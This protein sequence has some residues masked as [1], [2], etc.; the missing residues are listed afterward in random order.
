MPVKKTKKPRTRKA[1]A[2]K[3]GLKQ[4]Q[5]QKQEQKVNVSV[6]AGGSGGGTQFIPMPS[7]PAFDYAQLASLIRPANTVDVPIR[8]QVNPEPLPAR[9]AEAPSLAEEMPSA[10]ARRG[11]PV[12]SKN[13]PKPVAYP[14]QSGYFDEPESGV[15]SEANVRATYQRVKASAKKLAASSG[16]EPSDEPIRFP[17]SRGGSGQSVQGS[18]RDLF[19]SGPTFSSGS[20]SD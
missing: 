2:K 14:V 1:Q 13:R 6:S 5:K 19:G 18:T 15:E 11:R 7:A 10:G 9:E 17:S 12:G 20:G 3:K 4:K 16:F 8:A